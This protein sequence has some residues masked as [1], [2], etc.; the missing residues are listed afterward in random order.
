MQTVRASVRRNRVAQVGSQNF[1]TD[2]Q[3]CGGVAACSD[4]A[5]LANPDERAEAF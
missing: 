3:A 1:H 4:F 5:I 2:W